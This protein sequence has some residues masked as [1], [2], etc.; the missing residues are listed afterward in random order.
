M[1]EESDADPLELHLFSPIESAEHVELL[2]VTAHFHRTGGRLALGHT[3][4]FGRP[5]L[6]SSECTYGLISLPYL[7]GPTLEVLRLNSKTVRFLWLVPVTQREVEFKK[8]HGQEALETR[9]EA[10]KF[11]CLD[12]KRSSVV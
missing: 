2:T 5:W 8:R 7:D 4:N 12:P 10:A 1:S 9:L 6:E 11:N 3:V